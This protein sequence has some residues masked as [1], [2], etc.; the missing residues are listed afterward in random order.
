MITVVK[1]IQSFFLCIFAT[2]SA[3][4]GSFV[5]GAAYAGCDPL[6][7]GTLF[8]IAVGAD[9]LEP[10][11]IMINPLDL[12]PNFSGMICGITGS[13]SCIMGI[14]VPVVISFL[15]PHVSDEQSGAVRTLF[16]TSC[17]SIYVLYRSIHIL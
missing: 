12:S 9:G 7:V 10:S 2:A 11:S 3:I 14:A 1:A 6:M 4:N 13:I 15:T 17:F 5:L 8:A 16:T